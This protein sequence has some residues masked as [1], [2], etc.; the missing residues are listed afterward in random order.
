G[1]DQA[2]DGTTASIVD[3][4]EKGISTGSM[5]KTFSLAGLRLGWI[6]GPE[7]IRERVSIH[8]DYNTISVGMLND[9]F[10]TLALENR[11]KILARNR[12]VTRTNLEILSQWVENEPHIDWVKPKS[13]TT[14]FLKYNLPI[15]SYD[16]CLKLL[17]RT[18]VLLTPGAA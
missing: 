14:A 10:A 8:R 1:T 2:G 12:K 5:S 3:L 7:E 18:G 11:D 15:P 16:F 4:Y 9:H 6:V 13:G 17:E